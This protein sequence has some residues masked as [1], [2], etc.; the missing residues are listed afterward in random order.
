MIAVFG[1][2]VSCVVSSPQSA[3]SCVVSSPQHPLN[4]KRK[5]NAKNTPSGVWS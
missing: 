2:T 4:I 1:S 5:A 3:V